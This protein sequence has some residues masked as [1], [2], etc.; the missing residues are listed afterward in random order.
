M[1]TAASFWEQ[2][3]ELIE[4]LKKLNAMVE[5]LTQTRSWR[6][7]QRVVFQMFKKK[8]LHAEDIDKNQYCKLIESRVKIEKQIW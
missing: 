4:N 2:K 5:R 6:Q 1:A 7:N 8:V 3:D